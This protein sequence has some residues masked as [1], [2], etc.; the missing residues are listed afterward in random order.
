[1]RNKFIILV[2]ALIL[3][4]AAVGIYIAVRNA[5]QSGGQGAQGTGGNLPSV[6]TST[7]PNQASTSTTSFPSGSTFQIGTD[8]GTVTVKNFYD[9]D[10]YITEDEQTVVLVEND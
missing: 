9:T 2:I 10:A 5:L 8:Q 7:L 4:V 1:M 3:V 6:V